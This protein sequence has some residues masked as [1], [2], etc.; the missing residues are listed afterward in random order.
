MASHAGQLWPSGQPPS[1]PEPELGE[2]RRLGG[3]ELS[4]SGLLG[5]TNA[6]PRRSTYQSAWTQA[7]WPGRPLQ[8]P[9]HNEKQRFCGRFVLASCADHAGVGP[10]FQ[11]LS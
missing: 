2:L 10:F 9:E 1:R 3:P 6:T 11:L 5:T 4:G 7:R 8:D